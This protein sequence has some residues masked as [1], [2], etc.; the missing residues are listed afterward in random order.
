MTYG[1]QFAQS[2]FRLAAIAPF[3]GHTAPQPPRC[4]SGLTALHL[5]S[6]SEYKVEI[7][8]ALVS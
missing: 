7:L 3:T 4:I 2:L 6:L 1:A 5:N 8:S